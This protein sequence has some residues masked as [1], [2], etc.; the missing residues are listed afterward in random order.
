MFKRICN[1]PFERLAQTRGSSGLD[2]EAD[3]TYAQ[4][5]ESEGLMQC[6]ISPPHPHA[7]P[8]NKSLIHKY[9]F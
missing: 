6:N 8:M 4:K 5:N 1:A 3:L 2:G 9:F 7:N